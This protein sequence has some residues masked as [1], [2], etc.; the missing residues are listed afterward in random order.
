MILA[1]TVDEGIQNYIVPCRFS[2][3][4]HEITEHHQDT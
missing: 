4:M 2:L 1:S 3:S